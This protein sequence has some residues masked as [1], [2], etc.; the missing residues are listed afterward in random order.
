MNEWMNEVQCLD[1]TV[2][3]RSQRSTAATTTTT[4]AKLF[5]HH[6]KRFLLKRNTL[7]KGIWG[8]KQRRVW[9]RLKGNTWKN[10]GKKWTLSKHRGK[11]QK[12]S[13]RESENKQCVQ[14]QQYFT[15]WKKV[16]HSATAAEKEKHCPTSRWK[17]DFWW[18]KAV[19]DTVGLWYCLNRARR[20]RRRHRRCRRPRR[21]LFLP[22]IF[23]V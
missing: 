2:L 16:A 3:A 21:E 1:E 17:T 13:E 4:T 8:L 18:L 22:I 5:F 20:H 10:S 14:V 12:R 6:L 19:A 15:K 9:G 7:L 23:V 11:Q